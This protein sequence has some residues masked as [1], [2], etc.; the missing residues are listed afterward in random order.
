[1]NK[2]ANTKNNIMVKNKTGSNIN[3]ILMRIF[4]LT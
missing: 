4:I 1:M 3:T 2:N